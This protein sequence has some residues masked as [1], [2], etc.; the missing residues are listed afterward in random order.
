MKARAIGAVLPDIPMVCGFACRPRASFR[1]IPEMA[2]T[3]KTFNRW[4]VIAAVCAGGAVDVWAQ[5]GGGPP[6]ERGQ[7]GPGGFGGPGGGRFGGGRGGGGMRAM[8]LLE[9]GSFIG[10]SMS[11]G[12]RFPNNPAVEAI[13]NLE[14]TD[15]QKDQLQKIREELGPAMEALGEDATDDERK[16]KLK[17]L[18]DRALKVLTREQSE[19]WDDGKE[20]YTA[21]V[22]EM[23]A[24]FQQRGPGG[25]PGMRGPRPDGGNGFPVGGEPRRPRP[26]STIIVPEGT[27]AVS[28]FNTGGPGPR[29]GDGVRLSFNFI[30]A[31]WPGVLKEFANRAG[32]TLDLTAVPPDTFNY[33]DNQEYT[34]TEAL[35]VL[36]GYLLQ[37]GY[38]LVRRDRFLVCIN[39]DDGI[40][41]NT[42]PSITVEELPQRGRNE[43][44]S[45]TIPL[46]SVE[47]DKVVAEIRELLGPQGKATAMKNTNSLVVM[48][49]GSNVRRVYGLLKNGISI[50]NRESAFKAIPVKHISALEAERMVR[51]LFG[52][53]PLTSSSVAT[54]PQFGGGGFPGGGFG[55]PFGGGFPGGFGGGDPRF[56]GGWSRD[57]GRDGRDQQQSAPQTSRSTSA[58]TQSPYVGKIQLAADTRTN[59]LLVT[60]SAA[61]VKLVE[62]AVKSFDTNKDVNGGEIRAEDNPIRLKA[63]SVAGADVAQVART[64]SLILPGLAIVDDARTAKLHIQGTDE[65]HREVEKLLKEIAGDG[66]SSSVAVINLIRLDPVG[67]AGT[68]KNLFSGEGARAPSIEADSQGRRLMVRGTPD[69]VTQVRAILTQLG[70]PGDGGAAAQGSQRGPIRTFPLQ[71]RDPEEL[72]PLLKQVWAT[73]GQP[74]IR[75]VVPSKPNVIEDRRTPS[76]SGSPLRDIFPP[77]DRGASSRSNNDERRTQAAPATPAKSASLQRLVS[78]EQEQPAEEAKPAQP[79]KGP[80]VI[81]GVNAVDDFLKS[82]L[83]PAPAAK[84]PAGDDAMPAEDNGTA[85]TGT[86]ATGGIIMQI[87]GG[88]IVIGG[89][90][91]KALDEIEVLLENLAATIPARTRWTVFYL[92]TADATETAQM[93]ERLFPQSTVTTSTQ[94]QDGLLGSFA[95]GFSSLGRGVM[96]V[97]G[98]NNTLGQQGL[99]IVTDVRANALFVTGPADKIEEIEQMLRLLDSSELPDSLRDKLPR[100]IPVEYAD[101]NDVAAVIEDV[102]KESM[103]AEQPVPGGQGGRG[104]GP[105]GFNPLAMLMAGQ[106][107]GGKGRGPELTLGV[108]TRTSHIIVSCNDNMFQKIEDLVTTMDQRAK[109]ARPTVRVV[110]LATADPT[111]VSGTVSSLF[112]KVSVSASKTPRT[113]RSSQSGQQSG[114]GASSGGGGA[115]PEVT[116]DPEMIRRMMEMRDRG[117]SGGGFP[118]PFGSGGPGG[119][120]PGGGSFFG[121]GNRGN[122]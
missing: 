2:H 75:V 1:R 103:Q 106:Q 117:N 28:S 59:H 33:L 116:R 114:G 26:D 97:T 92:R 48:D 93:L 46:E 34:V 107:G 32:L 66:G 61:H 43:L 113:S 84:T 121:R 71:G 37:K 44:V 49:I 65:E 7:G 109:E 15:D 115:P 60:A 108:D 64:L 63:Y 73:S 5:P 122:N 89:G 42:V 98:L 3:M 80:S 51:R 77:A 18:D 91:E 105:G 102:F 38:V 94:Q 78:Q 87:I 39:I 82:F 11:S 76:K 9:P 25:G 96:N 68:L 79:S 20:D 6:G 95:S 81:P 40:P 24:Q 22:T 72:L 56:G 69:Q 100:S 52:L 83:D 19:K 62:E 120:G 14:L 50:D 111:V 41:P 112:S 54:T 101:V 45:L 13:D 55:G 35:D 88:E 119:G 10:A 8:Q 67:A 53:N 36:N 21:K 47:A 70:E 74:P 27:P 4:L 110:P 12:F 58:G 90:D 57:G 17:E 99:R 118:T 16:A 104:G 85:A 29:G 30:G 23:R 86:D 31:P